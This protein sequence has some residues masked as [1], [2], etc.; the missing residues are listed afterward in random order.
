M[1]AGATSTSPTG[2][3]RSN[4]SVPSGSS[5]TCSRSGTAGTWTTPS[6]TYGAR[7]PPSPMRTSNI[8]H[9][10]S[11]S[12]S[13]STAAMSSLL[14]IISDTAFFARSSLIVVVSANPARLLPGGQILAAVLGMPVVAATGGDAAYG[15]AMLAAVRVGAATEDDLAAGCRLRTTSAA[16]SPTLR[17]AVSTT[18]SIRS[19]SR[20]TPTCVNTSPRWQRR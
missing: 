7:E 3:A 12:R 15:D 18:T 6:G 9:P 17:P 20:S 13:T 5:P 16:S 2:R 19:I 4:S 1:V 14:R 11:T 10:Y 8:S